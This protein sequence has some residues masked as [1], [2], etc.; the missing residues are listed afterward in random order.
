MSEP[1]NLAHDAS[2]AGRSKGGEAADSG[3]ALEEYNFEAPDEKTIQYLEK[4]WLRFCRS[5]GLEG[6]VPDIRAVIAAQATRPAPTPPP[7]H[8]LARPFLA[9]SRWLKAHPDTEEP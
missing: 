9:A 1:T 6:E 8:P 5:I 7:S 3:Y 2:G 4:Q